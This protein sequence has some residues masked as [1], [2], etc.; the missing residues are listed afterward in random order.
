MNMLEIVGASTLIIGG[1]FLGLALYYD[2]CKTTEN[3]HRKV[4]KRKQLKNRKS[5]IFQ[6]VA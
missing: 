6:N 2:I 4:I 5:N 1:G 3:I